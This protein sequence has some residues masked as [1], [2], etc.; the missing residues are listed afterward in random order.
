MIPITSRPRAPKSFVA[1]GSAGCRAV[2]ARRMAARAARLFTTP[3][4]AESRYP[5]VVA[6]YVKREI[7]K[8]T[9]SEGLATRSS[10][11][12]SSLPRSSRSAAPVVRRGVLFE[13]PTFS[14]EGEEQLMKRFSTILI[15][16][17]VVLIAAPAFAADRVIANGIDLWT[18]RGDGSTFADFSIESLPAGFFCSKSAPFT[19]QVVLRGVPIATGQ[20]GVL[21]TT[22]TIVQRLD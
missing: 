22:D 9:I 6:P 11:F 15:I 2:G 1:G 4:V 19:G 12:P 17:S 16:A 14:Q 20:P 18:T 5:P 8:S 10:A 13:N 3:S 21:G 7:R